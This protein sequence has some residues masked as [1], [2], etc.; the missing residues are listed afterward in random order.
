MLS[1][2]QTRPRQTHTRNK[3][4]EHEPCHIWVSQQSKR[5]TSTGHHTF[6]ATLGN[7]AMNFWGKFQSQILGTASEARHIVF[8]CFPAP[9]GFLGAG[10]SLQIVNKNHW[11]SMILNDVFFVFLGYT[12]WMQ[13]MDLRD[14]F[15]G[16]GI[17]WQHRM[18]TGVFG[19]GTPW[20]SLPP[21][22]KICLYSGT[23]Q[24]D[25]SLCKTLAN[26]Q[27]FFN[28]EKLDEFKIN[29]WQQVEVGTQ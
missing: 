5:R 19:W 27:V 28:Q 13:F 3:T 24:Q 11:E 2:S 6:G 22:W 9:F 10:F 23:H 12:P 15:F 7:I 26:C 14:F 29:R 20:R 18:D 4:A 17:K 21:K 16:H 8:G 25:F 1:T